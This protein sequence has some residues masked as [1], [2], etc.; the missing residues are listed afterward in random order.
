M[1]ERQ[2]PKRRTYSS[3]E[4]ARLLKAYQSSGVP[5]KQWCKDHPI[6]LSTLQRWLQEEKKPDPLQPAP[7]WVPVTL[8][9]APDAP[10]ALTVQI[11]KCTMVV[12]PQTDLK[13]LS[14]VVNLM[15]RLC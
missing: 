4:K 13:L 5:Q 12:D 3:A 2:R 7:T 6:G 14:A 8:A 9:T 1:E 15:V 10:A 11:G